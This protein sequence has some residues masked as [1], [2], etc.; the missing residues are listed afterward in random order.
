MVVANELKYSILYW[1]NPLHCDQFLIWPNSAT[2]SHF[3]YGQLQTIYIDSFQNHSKYV[4]KSDT[5]GP[6]KKF[7]LRGMYPFS[8]ILTQSSFF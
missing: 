5:F 7:T 3:Y 1:I 2:P 6:I 8:V 4:H